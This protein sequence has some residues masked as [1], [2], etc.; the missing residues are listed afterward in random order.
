MHIILSPI[1]VWGALSVV[2]ASGHCV[3]IR[4]GWIKKN[5]VGERTSIRVRAEMELRNAVGWIKKVVLQ[6]CKVHT[7]MEVTFPTWRLR[8]RSQYCMSHIG[9]RTMST[10]R[11]PHSRNT[12]VCKVFL[13]GSLQY[14]PL[15][16]VL[17]YARCYS[18]VTI[19]NRLRYLICWRDS[20]IVLRRKYTA[21]C[22]G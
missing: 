19:A 10:R 12:Y 17:F 20:I 3:V 21:P 8:I 5:M 4:H 22:H 16:A 9:G 15:G 14:P 11:H 7:W 1:S 6:V 13:S 2:S 18:M